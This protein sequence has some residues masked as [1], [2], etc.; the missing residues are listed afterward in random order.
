MVINILGSERESSE[1]RG[2][3][4]GVNP[5]WAMKRLNIEGIDNLIKILVLILQLLVHKSF[6]YKLLFIL[7]SGFQ[8]V[9]N[10]RLT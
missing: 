3:S 6:R 5:I 7:H 1:S 8:G 2:I 10:F 9:V 4:L